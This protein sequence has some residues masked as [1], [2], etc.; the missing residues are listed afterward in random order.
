MEIAVPIK[1]K[2]GLA[3]YSFS[4]LVFELLFNQSLTHKYKIIKKQ[5]QKKYVCQDDW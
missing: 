2:Q 4:T 1:V 5:K 3:I